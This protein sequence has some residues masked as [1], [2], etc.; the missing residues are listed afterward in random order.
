MG[1]R[2]PLSQ[3]HLNA[4]AVNRSNW[5]PLPGMRKMLCVVCDYYFATAKATDTCP[6]C[7]E[8]EQR[9]YAREGRQALAH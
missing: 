7:V 2:R 4:I 5:E 6:E 9:R 3:A 8:R 1:R